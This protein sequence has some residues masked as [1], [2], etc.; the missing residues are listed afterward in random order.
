VLGRRPGTS[1]YSRLSVA[2]SLFAD[3]TEL[4]TIP[5]SA[6]RPPPKGDSAVVVMKPR[7]DR[8][9]EINVDYPVRS[10][11]AALLFPPLP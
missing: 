6:F 1:N 8:V 2:C 5:R 10:Q 4:M 3:T 7:P 9:A 11:H